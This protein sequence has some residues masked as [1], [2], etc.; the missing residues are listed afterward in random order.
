MFKHWVWANS[1]T[2]TEAMEASSMPLILRGL[3]SH[4]HRLNTRHVLSESPSEVGISPSPYKK[5][6]LMCFN[7]R[8]QLNSLNKMRHSWPDHW[9]SLRVALWNP[10][11]SMILCF[12]SVYIAEKRT[13]PKRGWSRTFFFL[14]SCGAFA[15]SSK[16]TILLR[17]FSTLCTHKQHF[18]ES[19]TFCASLTGYACACSVSGAFACV[20]CGALHA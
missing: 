7:Y 3:W 20:R 16:I 19:L 2:K 4:T 15:E 13:Q 5:E 10:F 11:T 14:L 17:E 12:N 18:S 8:L 1:R 6:H 9:Q